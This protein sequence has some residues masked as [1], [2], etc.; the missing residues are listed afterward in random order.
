MRRI[1]DV[2]TDPLRILPNGEAL[3]EAKERLNS[4]GGYVRGDAFACV[5]KYVLNGLKLK[6]AEDLVFCNIYSLEKFPWR[7]EPKR[8][9][10]RV[11]R[12]RDPRTVDEIM[13][14]ELG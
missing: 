13:R 4:L 2:P 12:K 7:G 11:P 1:P 8:R 9:V 14:E 10:L 3:I 6:D 5:V